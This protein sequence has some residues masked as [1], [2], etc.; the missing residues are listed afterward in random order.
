MGVKWTFCMAQDKQKIDEE[1]LSEVQKILIKEL[2]AICA[3]GLLVL[4]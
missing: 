4:N 2:A 3:K 1:V